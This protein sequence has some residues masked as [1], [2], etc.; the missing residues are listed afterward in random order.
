[1]EIFLILNGYEI[2]SSVNEQEQIILDLAA[3]NL[4]RE[5][6]T[7]WVKTNVNHITNS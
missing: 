1:M 2:K 4:T 7:N 3:E 5:M 6:L